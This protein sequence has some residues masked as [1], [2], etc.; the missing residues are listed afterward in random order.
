M[1]GVH[2][3]VGTRGRGATRGW[4]TS[5]G[6]GATR[7]RGTAHSGAPACDREGGSTAN[8]LGVW[9]KAEPD[10]LCWNYCLTPGAKGHFPT[11]ISPF[12]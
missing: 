4:R 5:R 12:L 10:S 7:C 1:G 8:P 11:N 3:M 6:S 2:L 9:K